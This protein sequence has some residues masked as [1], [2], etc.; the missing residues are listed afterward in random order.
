MSEDGFMGEHVKALCFDAYQELTQ[1]GIIAV[2]RSGRITDI[3]QKYAH[4]LRI[5]AQDVIGKS[6]RDVIPI[7]EMLELMEN[8]IT[9][10]DVIRF[11]NTQ[12][13]IPSSKDQMA[14]LSR[15]PIKD[16]DGTIIGA[17]GY[18]RFYNQC[19]EEFYKM[20]KLYA[21]MSSTGECV[22]QSAVD[23]AYASLGTVSS[24]LTATEMI[25]LQ[26]KYYQ[27]E[28]ERLRIKEH[29][30]AI[31]VSPAFVDVKKKVSRIARTAF[32]VLL[33]GESG[34]GKEVIANL[35]HTSSNR[36][37]KLLVTINCAAIPADL[38]ESELFGYVKGA[39]TGANQ[40]GKL[41]KI[42]VAEGGS[43]FLDEIGDM[44]LALQAKLLRVLEN[45]EIEP[46]GATKAQKI[47]VRFI[48]AT[49]KI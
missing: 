45:K 7:S 1:D 26:L 49:R 37:N 34:T 38:L 8:D 23:K 11:I 42:A 39:F 9:D 29:S 32:S 22:F 30:A 48:S 16:I 14:L 20:D 35:I 10:R 2:D 3:N 33:T 27:E 28:L 13:L 25:A 36:A 41:G 15:T 12:D 21:E 19:R 24:E 4:M 6:I 18:L 40:T 46:I 44:P 5:R 17:V 31:G 43:I 47:D